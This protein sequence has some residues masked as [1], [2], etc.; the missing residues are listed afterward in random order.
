MIQ[1]A[2]T[3]FINSLFIKR[4]LYPQK[5]LCGKVLISIY[6]LIKLIILYIIKSPTP[7][8]QHPPAVSNPPTSTKEDSFFCT[9]WNDSLPVGQESGCEVFYWGYSLHSRKS[10][11][12]TRRQLETTKYS[13]PHPFEI[14]PKTF[15]HPQASPVVF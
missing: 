1:S 4:E 13:F 5:L 9:K 11:V 6:F 14:S 15:N 3:N 12:F 10:H 7:V 2:D 8:P